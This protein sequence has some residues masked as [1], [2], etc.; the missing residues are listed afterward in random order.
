MV[1]CSFTVMIGVGGGRIGVVRRSD[2]KS[3]RGEFRMVG[4]DKRQ[5]KGT[6]QKPPCGF[7][8]GLSGH[9]VECCL[10]VASN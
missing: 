7:A 10:S 8:L 2:R 6:E 9:K 5:H 1:W 4:A 3:R